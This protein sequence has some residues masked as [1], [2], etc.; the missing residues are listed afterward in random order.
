MK[1]NIITNIRQKINLKDLL[2]KTSS[3]DL[4]N[5]CEEKFL[6]IIFEIK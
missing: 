4:K 2:S 3:N 6:F 5:S 1:K